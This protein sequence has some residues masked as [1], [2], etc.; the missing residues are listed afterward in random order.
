MKPTTLRDDEIVTQH[1]P[2]LFRHLPRVE[3][4][5]VRHLLHE[6][7]AGRVELCTGGTA[8]LVVGALTLRLPVGALVGI[9]D[10]LQDALTRLAEAERAARDGASRPE[11]N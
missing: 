8:S 2:R 5:C 9:H 11:E 7:P 1:A 3:V 4:G 6:S 10:L